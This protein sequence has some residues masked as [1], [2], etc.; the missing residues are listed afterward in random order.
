MIDVCYTDPRIVALYDLDSTPEMLAITR[1]RE[2][3]NDEIWR[4]GTFGDF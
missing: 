3:G 4:D 2:G 1:T